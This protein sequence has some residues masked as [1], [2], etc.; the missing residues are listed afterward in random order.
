[1]SHDR[2]RPQPSPATRNQPTA[3]PAGRSETS[4]ASDIQSPL[5]LNRL[6]EAFAQM[7]SPHPAQAQ[8]AAGSER[9]AHGSS[10]GEGEHDA[11]PEHDPCEISPRSVVEAMLFVGYPDNRPSSARELAAAMRGVSP[12]E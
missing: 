8:A 7:L 1:M 4:A 9:K 3:S 12:A 2:S 6:R 5:S 10:A 11:A